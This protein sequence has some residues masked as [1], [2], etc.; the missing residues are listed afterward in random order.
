MK[1]RIT[2]IISVILSFSIASAKNNISTSLNLIPLPNKIVY[3]K[4]ELKLP[5]SLSVSAD[6][7][8][9]SNQLIL[10]SLQEELKVKTQNAEN[11][12]SL[13]QYFRDTSLEDEE[14][15]IKIDT[16][17]IQI[18]SSSDNGC[19][20]ASTT[21]A[22]IFTETNLKYVGHNKIIPT[23]TIE[24]KPRY[25][26]RSFHID[27]ARHMFTLDYLKKTVE[28]IA[29]YKINKLHLHLND[30]QGWRIEIDKYPRL[31]EI[32]AWRE[33]D[34]YDLRCIER[35]K[36]NADMEIDKRFLRSD[37][38]Y[39]GFYTKDEM[40][41]LISYA[42][43]YG[44]EII[45][46]IDMPG[47]MSSAIKA[48]PWL[49][50]VGDSGWGEEFSYPICPCSPSVLDF[51]KDIYAEIAEL[52]PSPYL[53]IG[54]DEVERNTWENSKEC[55]KMMEQ[56]KMKSS[57]ELQT[58]FVNEISSFLTQR[59]K[60]V[61]VWDDAALGNIDNNTLVMHW[62]DWMNEN[63]KKIIGKGHPMI[64]TTWSHFY[65]SSWSEFDLWKGIYEF[66]ITKDYPRMTPDAVIGYQACVWTEEIPNE[67][68][69]EEHVYPS[70]QAFSEFIWTTDQNREWSDF[71]KRM[72]LHQ[73]MMDTKGIRYHVFDY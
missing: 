61:I 73:R 29:Y 15:K 40:R 67:T 4:G 32:G 21:L 64:F 62:R 66:D 70:L 12:N 10:N 65:F 24:D 20:L 47:H 71:T 63:P 16:N 45:P 37:S 33:L 46:E 58:Y 11:K 56:M 72:K 8:Q 43:Q 42:Q 28:R 34:K 5:S 50:C 1:L 22:Q 17:N 7:D 69:F 18:Y 27:V 31:T 38:I 25:G 3:D 30:D 6:F 36:Y 57:E 41:E 53:H 26:W 13:I 39:G 68:K 44:V 59:G 9:K 23:L 19:F 48:Y 35:S 52:F 60:T 49:S 55:K 54:A 14:Y 51:A 2:I